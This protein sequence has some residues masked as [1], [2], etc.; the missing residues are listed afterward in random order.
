MRNYQFSLDTPNIDNPTFRT[1][2]LAEVVA[3]WSYYL[4]LSLFENS[5][6][7]DMVIEELQALDNSV[8]SW[9]R[10][11]DGLEFRLVRV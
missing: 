4:R 5:G 11:L 9:S 2:P 6:Q 10:T 1:A 7:S 3:Q 8:S